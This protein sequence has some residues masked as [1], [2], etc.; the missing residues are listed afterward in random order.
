MGG[1]TAAAAASSSGDGDGRG[2]VKKSRKRSAAGSP[3][4]GATASEAAAAAVSA[5]PVKKRKAV[6]MNPLP[7]GRP[8]RVFAD[9]IFDLFHFGHARVLEQAKNIFPGHEVH[10][11]VGICSDEDTHRYKGKTVMTEEERIESVRHCRHVDEI[12]ERSPWVLTNEFL[13]KHRIDYVAHDDL[14]YPDASGAADDV[15]AFVKQQG[16]FVPTKRTEGISTSDLINRIVKDYDNFVRRNL[17]RGFSRKDMNISYLREKR[18]QMAERVGRQVDEI[19]NNIKDN[20]TEISDSLGYWMD[21]S[22]NLIDDFLKLFSR[23]GRLNQFVRESSERFS[24]IAKTTP[25]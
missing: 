18:I 16:M 4:L 11:V 25:M 13:E 10:L 7:V 21:N 14:P 22:I 12:I 15:Y 17:A 6:P 20:V 8:I 2:L 24:N 9:G 23:E 5:S 1:D 3:L 19:K